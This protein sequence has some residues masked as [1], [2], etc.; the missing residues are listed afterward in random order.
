MDS[1]GGPELLEFEDDDGLEGRFGHSIFAIRY[2]DLLKR[3]D[4]T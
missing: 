4:Y 1:R 2:S 3:G